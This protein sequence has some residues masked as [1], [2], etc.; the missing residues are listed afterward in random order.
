MVFPCEMEKKSPIRNKQI[1]G[2]S[3]TQP[4]APTQSWSSIRL[5]ELD[6]PK[7]NNPNTG[8]RGHVTFAIAFRK[9]IEKL[10]TYGLHRK[11]KYN[12]VILIK[13]TYSMK[14]NIK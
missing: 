7:A 14:F 11:R 2:P 1:N 9:Q 12:L 4:I 8:R 5:Y 10:S 13:I 6:S 3:L